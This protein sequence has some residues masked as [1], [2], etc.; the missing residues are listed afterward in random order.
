M[1]KTVLFQTIQFRMSTQFNSI[2]PIDGTLSN[3]T[4]MCQ[5][6]TGSNDSEGLL[7]RITGASTS[8]CFM[9]YMG[10][11]LKQFYSSAEM[12]SMYSTAPADWVNRLI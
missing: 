2:K 6:G 1:L 7:H 3:A 9:S 12:Q 5:S 10:H 11:S 4:T 8:D